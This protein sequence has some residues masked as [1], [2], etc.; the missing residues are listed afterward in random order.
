MALCQL[1]PGI[2]ASAAANSLSIVLPASSSSSSSSP[3]ASVFDEGTHLYYSTKYSGVDAVS[4]KG[5]GH[6]EPQRWEAAF[7]DVH[8]VARIDI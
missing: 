6:F 1:I 3:S 4:F 5:P 8:L 7:S 2:T